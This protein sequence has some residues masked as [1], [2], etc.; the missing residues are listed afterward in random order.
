MALD[1]GHPIPIRARIAHAFDG[2]TRLPGEAGRAGCPALDADKAEPAVTPAVR[3]PDATDLAA[4]HPTAVGT[5][6]GAS[7]A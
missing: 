6:V 4:R 1:R 7:P 3:L 2:V 5:R